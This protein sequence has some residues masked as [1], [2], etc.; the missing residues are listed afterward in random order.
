MNSDDLA[1][2]ASFPHP[3]PSSTEPSS[4]NALKNRPFDDTLH[5]D[6][7]LYSRVRETQGKSRR[8]YLSR[9]TSPNSLTNLQTESSSPARLKPFVS[10]AAKL[11]EMPSG[12]FPIYCETISTTPKRLSHVFNNLRTPCLSLLHFA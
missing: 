3:Y 2:M 5:G 8:I 7:Q 6:V 10:I 9:I 1:P 4:Q 11:Q 12:L